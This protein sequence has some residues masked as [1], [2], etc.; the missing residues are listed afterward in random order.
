MAYD[1]DLAERIRD[2][3]AGESDL[4]EQKMF[5]GLAFLLSGNM[6][7]CASRE[8]GILVRI[9]P[10]ERERLLASTAA[11]PM[12]MGGR[13]MTGFLRVEPEDVRTEDQLATWV[14]RGAAH[15]RTLPPK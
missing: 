13:T 1:E 15:A 7:V 3:L 6:A 11:F 14:G 9:D 12:V 2:L 4:S 8:G 5:G 10:A